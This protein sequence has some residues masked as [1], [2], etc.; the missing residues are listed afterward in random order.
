MSTVD[1]PTD[2]PT[3]AS[4]VAETWLSQL[5]R[6]PRSSWLAPICVLLERL[7]IA[8]EHA[9]GNA[10]DLTDADL[11]T[12]EALT[13]LVASLVRQCRNASTPVLHL[14]AEI[15]AEIFLIVR[16]VHDP[17]WRDD[18]SMAMEWIR[19]CT[20]VCHKWREVCIRFVHPT[21]HEVTP[22]DRLP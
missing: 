1:V 18:T 22:I 7:P 16:D 12:L 19:A 6:L 15:L 13:P 10:G 2:V 3:E 14:P 11:C 17:D 20:H 4:V 9:G 8:L 21:I 5:A